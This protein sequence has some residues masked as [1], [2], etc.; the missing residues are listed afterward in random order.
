MNPSKLPA[1]VTPRQVEEELII[2]ADEE[3]SDEEEPVPGQPSNHSLV[4]TRTRR[5]LPAKPTAAWQDEDD[6]QVEVDIDQKGRT[7]KLRETEEENG[8]LS[9]VD[10]VARLRAL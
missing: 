9:G 2:G 7:R 1:P 5:L 4:C 3:D 6:E 8:T 10:Y